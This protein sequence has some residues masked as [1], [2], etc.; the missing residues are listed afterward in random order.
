MTRKTQSTASLEECRKVA[1]SLP[2]EASERWQTVLVQEGALAFPDVIA[3]F[4][5]REYYKGSVFYRNPGHTTSLEFRY[6]VT[7][8]KY[9]F[10]IRCIEANGVPCSDGLQVGVS[11]HGLPM[12]AR[13]AACCIA[14]DAWHK[15]V[16]LMAK[17]EAERA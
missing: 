6:R 2:R 15:A 13:E 14:S 7:H 11:A 4:K 12:T 1:A 16:N 5:Q 8:S 9:G 17:M 10:S 3:H